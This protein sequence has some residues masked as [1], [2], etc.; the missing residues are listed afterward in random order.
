[1]TIKA[2]D[3]KSFWKKG[4]LLGLLLGVTATIMIV[5]ASGF[6]IDTTNKD[7]FCASC[8]IMVPFQT[9]WK[10]AVHGGNN[11]QGFA[12]QCVDC[13][14]PHGRFLEYIFVKGKTGMGDIIQNFY[15]DGA[16]VDWAKL[17][18]KNRLKFTFES[19]CKHC[20]YNLTPPGLPSGGFI[21]HRSYLRGTANKTCAECHPHVGHK[22]MIETATQFFQKKEVAKF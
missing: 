4:W 1:M 20:H 10:E 3:K 19:A 14:L 9:S 2:P 16:E 22:N 17:A 6:M 7:V 18:E 13:H 5:L 11:P 8:H 21:A 12:A 15:V